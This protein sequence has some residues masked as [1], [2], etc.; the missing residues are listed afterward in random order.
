[1]PVLWDKKRNTIVNNESSEIIRMLNSAFDEVGALA[2]DY[3][4]AELRPEIDAI[5]Q[6]VYDTVNN[7]VYKSG[8]ATT[9]EAYEEAVTRCSRAWAG[10]RTGCPPAL[11]RRR[12]AHRGGTGGFHDARQ[13]RPGYVGQ[14][15]APCALG[16]SIPTCGRILA[17]STSVLA[18]P[19]RSIWTTSMRHYYESHK[20]INPTGIVPK[21]PLIDFSRR[22]AGTGS[23]DP[24]PDAA[25]VAPR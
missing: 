4:P 12:P 10:S 11:P 22:T 9:Q 16:G 6:R 7:G 2:G 24:G 25:G 19:R 20:S 21:G 17:N 1:V 13:V 8:F 3:Y 14:S 5:N 18:L 15:S 23:R